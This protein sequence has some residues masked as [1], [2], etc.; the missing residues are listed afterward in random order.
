[1][2]RGGDSSDVCFSGYCLLPYFQRAVMVYRDSRAPGRNRVTGY[3][4][5]S[6]DE[7]DRP[8][9]LLSHSFAAADWLVSLPARNFL[10]IGPELAAG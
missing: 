2:R 10:Y 4:Q 9:G 1:M 8:P 7:L 3:F 6:P 5:R